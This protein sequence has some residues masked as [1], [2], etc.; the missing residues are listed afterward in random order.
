MSWGTSEPKKEGWYLCTV[1]D[2]GYNYVL[3]LDRCEYPPGNWTWHGL[4]HGEVIA[5]I[6]FPEP[7]KGE[8]K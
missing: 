2:G 7:W 4:N 8:K 3:P 6:K 5:S 1:W